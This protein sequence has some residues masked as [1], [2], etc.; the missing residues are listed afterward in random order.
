MRVGGAVP[1]A[2]A[3]TLSVLLP[4]VQAKVIFSTSPA[5]A[6]NLLREAFPV[7]NGQLGGQCTQCYINQLLIFNSYV[8]RAAQHGEDP[9]EP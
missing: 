3:V 7:G 6:A 4:G 5:N 2:L 9:P 1:V 8:F